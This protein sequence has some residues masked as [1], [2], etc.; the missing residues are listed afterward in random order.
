[1]L[2]AACWPKGTGSGLYFLVDTDW[3]SKAQIL[4]RDQEN[5][6]Q[7]DD[8]PDWDW[9]SDSLAFIPKSTEKERKSFYTGWYWFSWG[10]IQGLI[11]F[12]GHFSYLPV[13]TSIIKWDIWNGSAVGCIVNI[14]HVLNT[15]FPTCGVAVNLQE[16]ELSGKKLDA[17]GRWLRPQPVPSLCAS[18]MPWDEQLSWHV[19]CVPTAMFC[20][21]KDP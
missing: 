9:R 15:W 16:L 5:T 13:I 1:M 2:K 6:S 12:I 18:A 4:G 8:P 11:L 20:L 21:I 10:K 17:P 3:V 7:C 19:F 14:L